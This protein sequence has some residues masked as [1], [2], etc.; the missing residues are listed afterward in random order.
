MKVSYQHVDPTGRFSFTAP[1]GAE[2]VV[3]D[4]PFATD[5]LVEIAYLD[6]VPF[7]KRAGK[8]AGEES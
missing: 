6:S 4:K 5:N 2:R 8:R 1:N 3:G 7:V